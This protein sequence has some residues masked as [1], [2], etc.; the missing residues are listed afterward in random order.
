LRVPGTGKFSSQPDGLFIKVE[1]TESKMGLRFPFADAVIVEACGVSQNLGD[2]RSKYANST[3]STVVELK[4]SWLQHSYKIR[5][6]AGSTRKYM[7]RLGLPNGDCQIPIRHMRVLYALD[8]Q[9]YD[10]M[11]WE[12]VPA[13]HEYFIRY[14]SM[15]T[16]NSPAF[17]QFTSLMSMESHFLTTSRARKRR[18]KSDEVEDHSNEIEKESK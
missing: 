15:S 12:I 4:S 1:W 11:R 18:S 7:D 5:G 13:G 2:K 16:S 9:L 8:D 10:A 17:R 14:S 3:A 6:K